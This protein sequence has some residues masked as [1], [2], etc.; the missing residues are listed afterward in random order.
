MTQPPFVLTR[1]DPSTSAR[2]GTVLT[3]HGPV[4]T[5]LFMPV[6]TRATVKGVLPDRL[7][8][9]GAQTVLANT[10]HLFLRPG[11]AVVEA[12]GGLGAFMGWQGTTL[13]DSGGFQVFSLADT[14]NVTD[15]GVAFSSIVDGAKHFWTPEDNMAIQQRIGADIVMQL[16]Q[17]P[18]YPAQR[19]TVETA[20]RRSA[21]WARRCRDA[22][23]REDQLLFGIVQGGVHADLRRESVERLVEIGFP[24]YGIGGYSVGE[25]H[26]LMLESLAPVC[27]A[28]PAD[29]PRYLMGVGNPT[30]ILRAIAL[31][32]DMF[33]C[34]LPTRTARLGTAFS[35]EGRLN[36]RNARFATDNGPL[37]PACSC[38]TCTTFTRS[39]IRHLVTTKE[40]LGA[41]LLSEHNLFYLL[42]LTARARV[43]IE[44]GRYAP[45]LAG[46]MASPAALDY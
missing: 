38:P 34:V 29:R 16:D 17:C 19:S 28:L 42:D 24:G 39:Y 15:E 13:T 27:A 11:D 40:M 35:S 8:L 22:H 37:D 14:V 31:G 1:T 12:A 20:V 7:S 21:D 41:V 32:V 5:P 30:T 33:D 25:P 2:R 6:G 23:S 26:D 43:A 3:A 36:L 18:P 44:E 45:F 4:E 46:W 9:L 10:Y